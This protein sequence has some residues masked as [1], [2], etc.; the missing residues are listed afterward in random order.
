MLSNYCYFYCRVFIDNIFYSKVGVNLIL[1]MAGG[2]TKFTPCMDLYIY[3]DN[4]RE[5]RVSQWPV[6]SHKKD[7]QFTNELIT[8]MS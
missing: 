1:P 7:I 6:F 4:W 3:H 8:H 5:S 2:V